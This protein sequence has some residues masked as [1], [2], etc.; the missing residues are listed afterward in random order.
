M[1]VFWSW[2][3]DTPGKIG[4]H[5]VRAALADAIEVLKQPEEIEEP[6]ERDA[7]AALHLDHDRQGVPGSPDLAPT[8]FRKIDQSAVFVADVTLVAHIQ[9]EEVADWDSAT[10]KLINSNV[11]IEYGY[12]LRALGDRS[13][14]TVQ[15]VHY[16]EREQLPFVGRYRG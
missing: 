2:Q 5:F 4:R 13:I 8:I 14:L 12:A 15:N 3:A 16:G 9:G 10:K 1:K 7:R 11:A 6:A